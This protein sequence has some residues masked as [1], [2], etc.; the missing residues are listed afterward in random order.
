MIKVR[1]SKKSN[2]E[3]TFRTPLKDLDYIYHPPKI[4]LP[5]II[6]SSTHNS[7]G[8]RTSDL[9]K[10]EIIENGYLVT[11]RNSTYLLEVLDDQLH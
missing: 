9:Q 3:N 7:G 6:L 4:G 1:V 11:T 2:N 5:L 8:I 10:V